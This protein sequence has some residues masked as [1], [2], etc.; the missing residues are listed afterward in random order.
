MGCGLGMMAVGISLKSKKIDPVKKPGLD[1]AL[2]QLKAF[3][4]DF[5]RLTSEDAAAFDLFMAAA[6]LP[7]DDASRPAKMQ[8]ALKHAAEVPLSTTEAAGKAYALAERTLPLC[9]QAVAS[10]M[11]CARHLLRA[12][13]PRKRADQFGWDQTPLP[14]PG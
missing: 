8:Q 1:Q 11:N 9:G 2:V 5:Q 14:L 7:K 6:A 4:A 3:K 12:A 13:A 10:D